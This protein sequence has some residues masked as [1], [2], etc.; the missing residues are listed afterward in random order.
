MIIVEGPDGAGKTTFVTRLSESLKLPVAPKVV[1]SDTNAMVDLVKWVEI[2]LS[3]GLK[4]VIFDR[5][6]LI[7]EPI[8]GPLLRAEGMHPGFNNLHW[9]RERQGELR[10]MKPLTIFCLPPLEVVQGNV[11]GD[12]D[13]KV[14]YPYI[15]EI[16]W[17][18]FNQAARTP[19]AL[20]WDYTR[21]SFEGFARITQQ[22]LQKKGLV[23]AR[24]SV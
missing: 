18:Y 9:L 15:K 5:H 19:H 14:I 24:E 8:Y 20:V 21:D 6:R 23:D 22:W 13:N 10:R 7:S 1:D 2:N 16:Y 3:D 4:P 11:D 12:S 17:L